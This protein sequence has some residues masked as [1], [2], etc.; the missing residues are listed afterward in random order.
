VSG[1]P[2][3]LAAR[4]RSREPLVGTVA[5]VPDAALTELLC[6][7]FDFVWIDLEHGQLG[8]REAQLMAIAARAAG[9]AALVRLPHAGTELLPALLDAGIDGVVAPRV[10][11]AAAAGRLAERLRY[12]PAGSRGTA[13][14]RASSWGRAPDG[15]EPACVVQIESAAGAARAEAI[16]A[17]DGVDALVVG[18]SDL[19]RDL[20]VPGQLRDPR[21]VEAVRTV[22]R[23]AKDAGVASG[24][25][26]PTAATLAALHAGRSTLAVYSS[27]VR[28]YATAVDGDAAELARVLTGEASPAWPST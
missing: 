27:D 24:V 22:Q 19:S 28:I 17:V 15:P 10:E 3:P 1:S 5:S 21:L 6:E 7:R 8:A 9:C 2:A 16:A 14:R 26:A 23:A 20:G 4:L 11:D 13:P 18:S 12:P 25:A